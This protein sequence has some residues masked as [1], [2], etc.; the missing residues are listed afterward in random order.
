MGGHCWWRKG[1]LLLLPRSVGKRGRVV[2]DRHAEDY[3][4]LR[5]NDVINSNDTVLLL[6]GAAL[7]LCIR[8][9]VH[10]TIIISV[11]I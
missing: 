7:W 8:L 11:V 3:R 4:H 1:S 9:I 5:G 6:S 2:L 10:S